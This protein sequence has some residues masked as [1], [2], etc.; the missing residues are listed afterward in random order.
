MTRLVAVVVAVALCAGGAWAA[1]PAQVKAKDAP[2]LVAGIIDPIVTVSPQVLTLKSG[3]QGTVTWT[4]QVPATEPAP[5]TGILWT[6]P[7]PDGFVPVSGLVE[8]PGYT[9]PGFSITNV[10]T[11]TWDGGGYAESNPVT[12]EVPDTV[13]PPVGEALPIPPAGGEWLAGVPE[14]APGNYASVAITLQAQ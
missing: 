6:W 4:I 14:I 12:V 1:K 9:E 8:M 2:A 10:A 7:H 3:E 5:A 13:Y 11:V